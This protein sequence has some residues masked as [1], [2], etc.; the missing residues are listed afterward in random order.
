M[1]D[2][3][4]IGEIKGEK[5]ETEDPVQIKQYTKA[6]RWSAFF[7][8]LIIGPGSFLLFLPENTFEKGAVEALVWLGVFGFLLASGYTIVQMLWR[9]LW[10]K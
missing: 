7:A 3:A 6:Q 2:A 9:A 10:R 4:S 5:M 8:L 1:G